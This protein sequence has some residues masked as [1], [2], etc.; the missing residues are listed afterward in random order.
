MDFGRAWKNGI[1]L[2]ANY[3][4]QNGF[5]EHGSTKY[6][7]GQGV[8]GTVLDATKAFDIFDEVL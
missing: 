4:L 8:Y 5:K 1:V 3:D 6:I 7:Y 2:G